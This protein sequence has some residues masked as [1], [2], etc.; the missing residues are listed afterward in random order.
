VPGN[1]CNAATYAGTS[2]PGSAGN[3]GSGGNAGGAG[4]PGA[5]GN[6][7]SASS[8]PWS[9]KFA[10]KEQ[11]PYNVGSGAYTNGQITFTWSRQ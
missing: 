1:A 11:I 9:R 2:S 4:N 8:T 6:P 10:L 7:G 3:P 5:G